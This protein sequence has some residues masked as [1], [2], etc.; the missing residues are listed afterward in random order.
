MLTKLEKIAMAQKLVKDAKERKGL[1]LAFLSELTA[2][3]EINRLEKVNPM[4]TY[5]EL[6]DL[7][8][9]FTPW[10][11]KEEIEA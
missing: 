6:F 9:F 1:H 8:K 11:T 3:T 5:D 4:A 7:A 2:L 10:V